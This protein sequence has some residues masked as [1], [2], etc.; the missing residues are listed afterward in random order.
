[1]KRVFFILLDKVCESI[2]LGDDDA[3]ESIISKCY[4]KADISSDIFNKSYKQI[5][6][7]YCEKQKDST[8]GGEAKLKAIEN[9]YLKYLGTVTDIEFDCRTPE[10]SC[11][12]VV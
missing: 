8:N 12:V 7:E 1:M 6:D 4:N 11:L 2:F 5:Y 10:M 3:L 9:K